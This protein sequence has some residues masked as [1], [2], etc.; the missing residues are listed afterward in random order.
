MC[1]VI[2]AHQRSPLKFSPVLFSVLNKRCLFQKW[3]QCICNLL[4]THFLKNWRAF[5]SVSLYALVYSTSRMGVRM[6][7]SQLLQRR[8]LE[9]NGAS[10]C[11]RVSADLSLHHTLKCAPMCPSGH[12]PN[13]YIFEILDIAYT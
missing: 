9:W 7:W 6:K 13:L 4:S 3:K 11:C 2:K 10:F 8:G 1:A 12:L 5:I